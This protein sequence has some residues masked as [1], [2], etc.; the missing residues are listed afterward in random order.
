MSKINLEEVLL[1]QY[2][3]AINIQKLIQNQ[4]KWID[5]NHNDFWD[6]WYRDVFDLRTCN[7]FGISVWA[8]ILGVSFNVNKSDEGKNVWGFDTDTP[9]NFFYANFSAIAS[10]SVNLTLEEKRKILQLRYYNMIT[11]ATIPEMNRAI[12]AIFGEGYVEDDGTMD[13]KVPLSV[14][15][16]SRLQY[17]LDNFNPIPVPSGCKLTYYVV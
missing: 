15:P 8:I 6:N 1:W 12:K 14:A 3:D 5:E 4:Q 2:N 10:G 7:E 17:I 9:N 11:R 16:N 13:L